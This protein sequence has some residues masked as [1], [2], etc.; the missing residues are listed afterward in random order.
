M[1][2]VLLAAG[3]GSRL[4]LNVTNKCFV[5][6]CDKYLLDYNLEQFLDINLSEIVIVIGHNAEYIVDYLGNSYHGIPII[7]V[8]QEQLLGIAH[9]MKIASPYIHDAFIMCLS[10]ELFINHNIKN[11]CTYFSENHLDCLCGVVK[12]TVE[13]I[14][15]AYT[16]DITPT[17]NILQLIEK[18]TFVFNNWKG[19]GC[20]FMNRTML[21][22]LK[23]LQPNS[24]R[25]EYEMGDWIQLAIDK[26]FTCKIYPIASANFNL[27]TQ[28]DI[29]LAETY[30]K[31]VKGVKN[32][33]NNTKYYH[34]I[35][36]K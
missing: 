23:I 36:P 32:E 21:N 5:K 33:K 31:K 4:G 7:Y 26:G 2:L 14:Q 16:I 20:C 1:Q 3:I 11:M 10:D 9:A 30:L 17:N 6:I 18:P 13:N 34:A 24:T 19:T 29:V 28:K 8:K 27:N 22:L 12:D 15:K 25:K 35:S